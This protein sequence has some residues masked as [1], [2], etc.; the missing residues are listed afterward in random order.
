[1]IK[2]TFT[3]AGSGVTTATANPASGRGVAPKGAAQCH[4]PHDIAESKASLSGA[5]G[6]RATG[7]YL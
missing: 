6:V 4:P 3:V 2:T 7:N 1:M 5:P